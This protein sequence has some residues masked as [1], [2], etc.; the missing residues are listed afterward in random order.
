MFTDARLVPQT[1]VAS[2]FCW[3][4]GPFASVAFAGD[5]PRSLGSRTTQF[6]QQAPIIQSP[7]PPLAD[8]GQRNV[9]PVPQPRLLAPTVPVPIQGP[10]EFRE[11]PPTPVVALRIRVP[12]NAAAGQD[13]EYRI[14]I[15]NLSAAPAHHVIVRNPL[16]ANARFVRANPEPS[17]KEPELIWNLGTLA[18]CACKEI[19]LVL[20]PTG[21]GDIQDC[22]RVQ[23]EHGQCVT[24]RIARPAI[25][26]LKTGPAQA[27]LNGL[28]TYQLTVTNTGATELTGVVLTDKLPTGLVHS[29]GQR[30]LSW[31]LGTLAPGQSRSVDYQVTATSAGKLR[32]KA[33]ATAAGG[34]RDEV[35]HELQV[36]E[37]KIGLTMTGP[38]KRIVGAATPYQITV[39][40]GGTVPLANVVIN[41]P[42][43]PQM[44]YDSAGSPGKF[45]KSAAPAMGADFVQWSIG[46][47]EPNA[48]KTVEVVLRSN[49]AGRICNRARA[50]ADGGQSALAEA[51]TEFTGE[52]GL[53]LAVVAIPNPAEVGSQISYPITIRNTG[54]ARVTNLR[55]KAD[56][57]EELK[58]ADV[59]T[60]LG[61]TYH[62]E[63]QILTFD[64][65]NLEPNQEARYV[66]KVD[67]MKA[68]NLRFKVEMYADQLPS[69]KVYR[70]APTTVANP[71]RN[72]QS[73]GQK[74]TI[75]SR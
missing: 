52:A 14:C 8:Q 36:A 61:T 74:K 24:T 22:A 62:Q 23:F 64:A 69:G 66:V 17:A 56:V 27:V 67:A 7:E 39:S 59:N 53:V 21:A 4:I 65:I 16:P 70:E 19:V 43:P 6:I 40:N 3:S 28:L 31:D 73:N 20:A 63:N 48:S 32:N 44:T 49:A 10:E 25:K 58:V 47:L 71:L 46:T 50:T 38:E 34:V 57:P 15:E 41:D 26:V 51:C 45:M 68:G 30:D 37:V 18:G 75:E 35:E 13:L 29:S 55:I 54:F 1:L 9:A 33:I 12:A 5:Q 2:I 42:I 11:D 60:P 72:G